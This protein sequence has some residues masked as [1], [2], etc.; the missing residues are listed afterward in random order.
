MFCCPN[1]ASQQEKINKK[2]FDSFD[3]YMAVWDWHHKNCTCGIMDLYEFAMEDQ[4]DHIRCYWVSLGRLKVRW[5][6]EHGMLL[7]YQGN[8]MWMSRIGYPY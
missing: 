8:F 2:K 6:K 4:D 7:D 5:H 1:R 3:E